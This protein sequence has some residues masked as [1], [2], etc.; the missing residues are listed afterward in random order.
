MANKALPVINLWAG[1]GAG[2]STT[3]AAVYA[4]LK[5]LGI[6]CEMSR[7]YAKDVVWGKNFN[8]LTDQ[9]YILGKQNHRLHIL[10][11]QCDVAIT[12]SPLLIG[13]LYDD[14]SLKNLQAIAMEAFNQYNNF[15]YFITRTKEYNPSGRM[16]TELEA[17][18]IDSLTR[19]LLDTLHIP[20]KVI[21]YGEAGVD[22]IVR[23]YT[24]AITNSSGIPTEDILS[25][26]RE[27][28]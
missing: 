17:R 14:K 10:K 16:Q 18:G 12:D 23:D 24:D 8:I 20:Y 19:D 25:A 6:N 15:N 27:G 13:L 21:P 4:R 28:N 11:D 1:P 22:I 9:L 2:K 26:L 7:E 3:C 5:T